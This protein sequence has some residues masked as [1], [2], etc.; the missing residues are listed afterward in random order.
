MKFQI[1][2]AT[3]VL[4][5][6]ACSSDDIVTEKYSDGTIKSETTME[7]EKKNGITKSYNKKGKLEYEGTFK[8]DT[9]VGIFKIF[10]PDGIRVWR[11]VDVHSKKG[12]V[13]KPMGTSYL[14]GTFDNANLIMNGV[15]EEWLIKENYKRFEWTYKNDTCDG[16]YKSF[17]IDGI[18]ETEGFYKKGLPDSVL[19]FFDDKGNCI[20]KELWTSNGKYSS[21]VKVLNCEYGNR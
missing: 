10:Y 14:M 13:Y 6:V 7:N 16:P 11:E 9:A 4:F 5:F 20:K 2:F 19:T 8:N 1:A 3:S 18:I 21:L 15:W 12:K 17:G